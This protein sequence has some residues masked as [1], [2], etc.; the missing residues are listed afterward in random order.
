M[1]KYGDDLEFRA[2]ERDVNSCWC[3]IIIIAIA[4]NLIIIYL[5]SVPSGP[6]LCIMLDIY[7]L[8]DVVQL[9]YL[10]KYHSSPYVTFY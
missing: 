4:L 5:V 7:L 10:H 6:I 8:S 3:I 9:M 1:Q 2:H